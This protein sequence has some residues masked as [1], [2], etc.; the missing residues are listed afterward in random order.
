MAQRNA[1]YDE[2]K[3]PEF[4]LP[5]ILKTKEGDHVGTIEEWETKRRLEIL[6]IFT[7]EMFGKVPN[8]E[9]L[10]TS[11]TTLEEGIWKDKISR[12]QVEIQFSKDGKTIPV[13]L[14]IYTP[15]DKENVP[16][17]IGYNF[18][19]NHTITNDPAVKLHQS[20]SMNSEALMVTDHKS[21][22]A[23][24][25]KRASR[26]PVEMI[27]DHGYGLVT[28]YYGDID[29]DRNDFEDG[30][31]SLFYQNGQ[32]EPKE[33]EW[34]SIA[35]WAWGMSRMV[36]YLEQTTDFSNSKLI[37]FGH[38]RLGKTSLWAGVNDERFDLVISNDSGCGGAALSK[39]KIGET[40]G[41][42][43]KSFPHW[44]NSKFKTFNENEE[45]MPFD[46]H[47]LLALIAPR[48]LYVA[49]AEEDL[50]ADPRGEYLSAYYASEVYRLYGLKGLT[51][52]DPPP[53]NEII[54]RQ[55]GYHK[56]TGKHDVTDFDWEQFITFA[57]DHLGD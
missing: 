41:V 46:Q 39:R 21:S 15:L 51:E 18:F 33:S 9:G 1:N 50:W 19:G 16:L 37:A 22:E 3:V 35:A 40:I 42:I 44:F 4:T 30:I 29:P 8:T 24:R 5:E 26:W 31:H 14:L 38:S 27:T 45:N 56:R 12:K 2:N 10:S 13:T 20:W 6:E 32:Q 55:I 23:S 34:G 7:K 28:A 48:P 47:M 25:G 53:V 17:F 57:K 49:S 52:K 43:N 36:D 54:H 11:Y